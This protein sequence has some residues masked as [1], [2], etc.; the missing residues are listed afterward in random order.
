MPKAHGV[1]GWDAITTYPQAM[2]EEL[3]KQYNQRWTAADQ[4]APEK[5]P[6]KFVLPNGYD[7]HVEHFTNFFEGIRSNKPIVEDPVFGFRAAAPC[8]A[9][10]ESY[11]QKKIIGWDPIN[12][13]LV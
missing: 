7:S 1:G 6:I 10:N 8:L 13:K 11:F 12:M 9:S 5:A 4:K 3:M 2:Q